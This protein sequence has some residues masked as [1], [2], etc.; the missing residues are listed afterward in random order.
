[1][2]AGPLAGSRV[3]IGRARGQEDALAM[4][5][6]AL[7]AEVVH[8]PLLLIEPGDASGLRRAVDA[9]A[10]GD[11]TVLAVTSPNGVD[12]L[13]AACQQAGHDVDV[14]RSPRLVAAVGPGTAASLEA[15]AG[16]APDV[17]PDVATTAA[18]G[19]AVPAGTGRALLPRADIANPVLSAR[20]R[21]KG[22]DPDEV[23]AYRTRAPEALSA[24]TSDALRAGAI[25]FVVLASSSTARH[26]ASL[27]PDG[28]QAQ[29]VSIGPVTTAT[30]REHGFEVAAEA[31]PH[32]LDGLV[33]AVVAAAT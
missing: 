17:I 28:W 14:L 3:L 23:T 21:E 32:D 30:C 25:D 27:A 9:L 2:T 26:F 29:V 7:G 10:A 33:A 5:L 22:Y 8:E 16:F 13:A 11:Y 24:E 1:M 19:A 12:A 6:R 15:T 18:L 31:S 4:R 20:L